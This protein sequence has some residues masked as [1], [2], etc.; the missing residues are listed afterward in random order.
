VLG[1]PENGSETADRGPCGIISRSDIGS[2]SLDYRSQTP[3]GSLSG[4]FTLQGYY[5]EYKK[6]SQVLSPPV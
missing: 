6:R 3:C 5:A 4:C 1:V 2:T